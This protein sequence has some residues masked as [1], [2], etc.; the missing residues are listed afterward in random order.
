MQEVTGY[1]GY[2]LVQ[3]MK[4]HRKFAETGLND[5]E[6]HVGQE[7]ILFQLDG[8]DGMTQS[9]LADALCVELPTA[10]KVLQRMETAGLIERRH[11]ASDARVSRVYLT[12]K[13]RQLIEPLLS[14]RVTGALATAA[15]AEYE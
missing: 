3:V 10:S 1:V 14:D 4:A 12:P 13:S 8:Q 7:L 2:L 15:D 9:E 5:F 11:D 6:L